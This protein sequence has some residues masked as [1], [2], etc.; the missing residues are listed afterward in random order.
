M[1]ICVYI[2]IYIYIHIHICWLAWPC[3]K[4]VFV[5]QT[6]VWYDITWVECEETVC[7]H[8]RNL[9]TTANKCLQCLVKIMY[10]VF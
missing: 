5:L 4:Q 3:A 1:Y 10:T 6:P 7:L 8:D 9:Y 2:Y